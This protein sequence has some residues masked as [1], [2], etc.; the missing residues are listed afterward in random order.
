[1][2]SNHISARHASLHLH[3]VPLRARF[4]DSNVRAQIRQL[5]YYA[6]RHSL[7]EFGRV[8]LRPALT[9]SHF[10]ILPTGRLRRH[11]PETHRVSALTAPQTSRAAT[12]PHTAIFP[13]PPYRSSSYCR[14][15]WP[16]NKSLPRLPLS[17]ELSSAARLRG[18]HTLGT[19]RKCG[20]PLSRLRRQLP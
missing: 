6:T 11:L 4:F 20:L 10:L 2:W 7:K 1:M 8:A 19:F 9:L 12:R 5:V 3:E 18:S 17:G 13:H 15:N 14:T 16:R